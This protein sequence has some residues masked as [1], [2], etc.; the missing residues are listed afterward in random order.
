[1]KISNRGGKTK[2]QRCLPTLGYST[3]LNNELSQ[4]IL[5]DHQNLL[6][7]QTTRHHTRAVDPTPPDLLHDILLLSKS[8]IQRPGAQHPPPR[9]RRGSSSTTSHSPHGLVPLQILVRTRDDQPLGIA[10]LINDVVQTPKDLLTLD[11]TQP[12]LLEGACDVAH[13]AGVPPVEEVDHG[14]IDVGRVVGLQLAQEQQR[15]L[16][17]VEPD[18]GGAGQGVVGVHGGHAPGQG[19]LVVAQCELPRLV[20]DVQQDGDRGQAAAAGEL[21]AL[22]GNRG[23]VEA[24]GYDDAGEEEEFPDLQA[25]FEGEAGEEGEE[26]GT[27]VVGGMGLGEVIVVEAVAADLEFQPKGFLLFFL[28]GVVDAPGGHFLSTKILDALLAWH[29]TSV[30]RLMMSDGRLW[31][32]P[33]VACPFAGDPLH[34]PQHL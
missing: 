2:R 17:K 32:Q 33:G 30:C 20:A 34:A 12:Q 9:Q 11:L 28:A 22:G 8:T 29:S 16:G 23:G 13:A 31:R 10:K 15:V 18:L 19:Q 14:G 24:G 6:V 5:L 1:M 4:P 25:E 7:P 27:A 21:G 3:V 26:V